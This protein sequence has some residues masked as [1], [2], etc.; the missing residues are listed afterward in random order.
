MSRLSGIHMELVSHQERFNTL[1]RPPVIVNDYDI[2]TNEDKK[3]LNELL[4]TEYD[5][6][7]LSAVPSC[8]C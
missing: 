3:A 5:G 4:F 7:T 8:S 6:D 1:Q 2:T